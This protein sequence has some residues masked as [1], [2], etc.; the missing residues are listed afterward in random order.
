MTPLITGWT[1]L[2]LGIRVADSWAKAHRI[3]SKASSIG[4]HAIKGIVHI[5]G[6]LKEIKAF[7]INGKTFTAL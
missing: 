4:L 3:D 5:E 6:L 2:K 1:G 7:Q